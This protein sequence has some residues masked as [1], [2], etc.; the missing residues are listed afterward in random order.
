MNFFSSLLQFSGSLFVSSKTDLLT[1]DTLTTFTNPVFN[2][3]AADPWVISH[4]GFYYSPTTSLSLDGSSIYLLKIHDLTD[5]DN[6]E[7][8]KIFSPPEGESYSQGIWAPE[9]HHINSKWYIIF[10]LDKSANPPTDDTLKKCKYYCPAVN[11]RM[12]VLESKDKDPLG[13]YS[14]LGQIPTYD[15]NGHDSFAIDG[16]YFVHNYKLYHIYR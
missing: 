3:S 9:L 1:N 7:A 13:P 10:S 14:F 16:T 12:F 2:Y 8:F 11:R 15:M 5:W 6:A 4:D